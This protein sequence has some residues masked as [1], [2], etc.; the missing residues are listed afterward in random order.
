MTEL[1]DFL[2]SLAHAKERLINHTRTGCSSP[3]LH[4]CLRRKAAFGTNAPLLRILASTS[5]CEAL[6]DDD[7]ASATNIQRKFSACQ[8]PCLLYL[9]IVMVEYEARTDL[10]DQFL[11]KLI[12]CI[13]ED[14]LD[15]DVSAEHLLIRLLGGL[16][17]TTARLTNRAH[18][19][20]RLATAIQKLG[21][22][23]RQRTDC[24]LLEALA[25]PGF[26][27]EWGISDSSLFAIAENL[28]GLPRDYYATD[29][30]RFMTVS[31]LFSNG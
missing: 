25:Y 17:D 14:S 8:T 31:T 1:S 18:R 22:R 2:V 7:A 11:G 29:M 10:L 4:G 5:L 9:N 24:A 26:E 19:T 30:D 6:A 3:C 13:Y 15:M 27:A 16:E 20:I 28:T 23:S 12:I 21:V